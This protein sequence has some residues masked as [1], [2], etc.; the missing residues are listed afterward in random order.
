MKAV[1][2]DLD[3]TLLGVDMYRDFLPG[4]T[5]RLAAFVAGRIPPDRFI[6]QLLASTDVMVRNRGGARTNREVFI[7]DFFRGIESCPE[8]WMPL[9]DR[10]YAEEFPA[11]KSLTSVQPGAR[12]AVEAAIGHGMS[13]AVATNPVFP[14]EAMVHRLTWAGL[15]DLPFAL[16]TSY[17]DMHACKPNPEYFSEVLDRMGCR[18]DE[19]LMVGNDV[20]EDLVASKVGMKTFLIINDYTVQRGKERAFHPDY[21]G[22]MGDLTDLLESK[23]V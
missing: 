12:S 8:E 4:Y 22:T 14:K 16:V 20:E 7:E 11:L 6:Q 13:V 21:E 5:K 10:F 2:F 3:G 23:A 19:A 1:L 9:F 17:E 15:N 18:P